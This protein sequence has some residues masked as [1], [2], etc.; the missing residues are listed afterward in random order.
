MEIPDGL[1]IGEEHD[2]RS[3]QQYH[4]AKREAVSWLMQLRTW[5]TKADLTFQSLAAP[6]RAEKA[7]RRWLQLVAPGA[8]AVVGFERQE[9]GAT[10]AHVI[11][12]TAIDFGRAERL[13]NRRSGFCRLAWIH[14]PPRSIDYAL[15]VKHTVKELDVDVYGPGQER[16]VYSTGQQLALLSTA[17]KLSGKSK[18][19]AKT[20]GDHPRARRRATRTRKCA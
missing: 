19:G 1:T 7:V 2:W 6:E 14:A 11:L 9:R 20:R 10:H 13:W 4:E 18:P 15:T 8:W 12:D 3:R 17:A 5:V 16:G